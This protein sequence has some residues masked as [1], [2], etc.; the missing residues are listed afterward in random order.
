MAVV[1]SAPPPPTPRA[2]SL[3]VNHNAAPQETLPAPLL[4]LAG[5]IIPPPD[6][7][8]PPTQRPDPRCTADPYLELT[9][10]PPLHPSFADHRGT[11]RKA[12]RYCQLDNTKASRKCARSTAESGK[13]KQREKLYKESRKIREIHSGPSSSFLLGQRSASSAS[14]SLLP[15]P[16]HPR[17]L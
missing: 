17:A 10:S 9:L 14:S 4:A 11:R 15:F 3:P 12:V 6:P 5:P 7:P 13:W 1:A 16:T 2:L 8:H